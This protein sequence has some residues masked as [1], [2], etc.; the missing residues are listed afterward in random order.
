MNFNVSI[1]SKILSVIIILH[2][3]IFTYPDR[4]D[5]DEFDYATCQ[6]EINFLDSL[7]TYLSLGFC[8]QDREDLRLSYFISL[9]TTIFLVFI[10]A[11]SLRMDY[12]R[13]KV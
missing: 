5:L 2:F 9:N 10:L 6:E 13:Q 11:L 7:N 12:S 8:S 4:K 3:I 1:F